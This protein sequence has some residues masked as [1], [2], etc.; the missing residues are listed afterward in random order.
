MRKGYRGWSKKR[1]SALMIPSSCTNRMQQ[2]KWLFFQSFFCKY[3]PKWETE[4]KKEKKRREI[5]KKK[6]YS[7][8]LNRNEHLHLILLERKAMFLLFLNLFMQLTKDNIYSC[9]SF[10]WA[11][12]QEPEVEREKEE[13]KGK[14]K[15]NKNKCYNIYTKLHKTYSTVLKCLNNS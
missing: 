2:L 5:K 15:K 11:L 9:Y 8:Y 7:G 6:I 14:R 1:E 3:R 10:S 13:G 12:K 4:K